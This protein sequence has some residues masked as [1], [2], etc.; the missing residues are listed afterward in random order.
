MVQGDT[1]G[2]TT[3]FGEP[4]PCGS[5][6]ATVWY[7]ITPSWNSRLALTTL[8]TDPNLGTFD[9]VLA[10]YIG[11]SLANLQMIDCNDDITNGASNRSGINLSQGV[12]GGQTYYV[13]VG[14]YLG[15]SGLFQLHLSYQKFSDARP[16][17]GDYKNWGAIACKQFNDVLQDPVQDG[18]QATWS[19]VDLNISNDA[20]ISGNFIA[21]V[22]WFFGDCGTPCP[23]WLEIGDTAGTGQIQGNTDKWERWWYWVDRTTPT[24]I[25]HGIGVAAND[26]LSRT[27]IIQWEPTENQW[28]VYIC[29][30]ACIREGSSVWRSPG[31]MGQQTEET[32]LEVSTDVN[33]TNSNSALMI[34]S[35]LQTRAYSNHQW[36]GWSS[37]AANAEIDA[38]CGFGYPTNYCLNG[39]WNAGP[40]PYDNWR[41]N[42][43]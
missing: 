17:N 19:S 29:P 34:D 9:T 22:V 7:K 21:Q 30:G 20:A 6:G 16:C 32:G 13:Q 12:T 2:A 38:G 1:T 14:G 42:K 15:Q 11:T 5:M 27:Y 23:N 43:P 10:I 33:N 37:N 28:G 35:A 18:V 26:G 39:I 31:S 4:L 25:E 3:E 40:P 24:Y 8:T 41:N 36:S